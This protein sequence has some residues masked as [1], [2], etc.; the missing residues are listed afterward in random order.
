[1]RYTKAYAIALLACASLAAPANATDLDTVNGWIAS[2]KPWKTCPS[3]SPAANP[4]HPGF[5]FNKAALNT[6]A[7]I[8]VCQQSGPHVWQATTNKAGMWW[9]QVI[10]NLRPTAARTIAA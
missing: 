10:T 6:V 1:M 3:T 9:V 4:N 5:A 2:N 7:P 8:G